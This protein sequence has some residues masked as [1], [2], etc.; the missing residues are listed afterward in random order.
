MLCADI[1]SETRPGGLLEQ[2]WTH[3]DQAAIAA[4]VTVMPWA[5]AVS[6]LPSDPVPGF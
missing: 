4:G 6:L 5:D 1:L 2:M 3:S